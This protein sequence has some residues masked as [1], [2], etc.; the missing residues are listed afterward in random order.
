VLEQPDRGG[1]SAYA[2]TGC[3]YHDVVKKKL[4][5]LARW[6][7]ETFPCEVK[8][9]VDTAPIMEKPLAQQAGVGWQGKHSNLVS[10]SHGSWLF[11]G[12]VLTSLDLP[13][14]LP[15]PDHCGSCQKCLD[16]CPTDAFPAPYQLDARRCIAY[17]TIEH[18]GHIP[19]EFRKPI[20]NRVFGCDDCLAVCPWNKFAET[21][22][23]M[24]MKAREELNA[25][26]LAELAALDDAA[27]RKLFAGSPV[28]RLG[29]DRLIRNVLIAMGNSGLADLLPH[30]DPHLTDPNPVV[31][32]A[33]VWALGQLAPQPAVSGLAAIHRPSETDADVLAEWGLACEAQ[34]GEDCH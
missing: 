27:F 33:A 32:A 2:Q 14:D 3:D 4:R 24:Q 5:Q 1:I 7:A 34:F 22:R 26:V 12:E 13:P 10:R 29:R 8:L 20:G 9:F 25:P 21:A 19:H 6:M 30:I 28:K 15:E 31:R 11:L 16:I 18:Q 23:D 17:L